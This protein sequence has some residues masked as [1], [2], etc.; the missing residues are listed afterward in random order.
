[1]CFAGSD[2][3]HHQISRLMTTSYVANVLRGSVAIQW[4]VHPE[5]RYTDSARDRKLPSSTENQQNDNDSLT[6]VRLSARWTPIHENL[7]LWRSTEIC[8]YFE[9]GS[10]RDEETIHILIASG[11]LK[12]DSTREDRARLHQSVLQHEIDTYSIRWQSAGGLWYFDFDRNDEKRF[13]TRSLNT[14]LTKYS[15]H[16]KINQKSHPRFRNYENRISTRSKNT[17][18][19]ENSSNYSAI[20]LLHQI[21]WN[22]LLFPAKWPLQGFDGGCWLLCWAIQAPAYCLRLWLHCERRF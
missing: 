15:I 11:W 8:W 4:I 5:K 16:W 12:N 20:W 9:F 10:V 19:I 6:L 18:S 22:I 2:P 1:M 14:P 13:S 3:K 17:P 7:I 21:H